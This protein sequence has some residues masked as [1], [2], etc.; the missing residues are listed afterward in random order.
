[1]RRLARACPKKSGEV[2]PQANANLI[3]D[4]S[5]RALKL[6]G[7]NLAIANLY[8]LLARRRRHCLRQ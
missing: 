2:L 7:S 5:H 8:S 1:V 3:S 4:L 6:R